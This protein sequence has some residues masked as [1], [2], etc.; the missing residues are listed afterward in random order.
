[1][2]DKYIVSAL[3]VVGTILSVVASS[4]Q[5]ELPGRVQ[6]AEDEQEETKALVLELG[7]E[8]WPSTRSSLGGN[9]EEIFSGAVLAVYDAGTGT[10]DSEI[11]IDGDDIGGKI[12][13][14][15]PSGKSY[16]FYL[17]GNLWEL[18][19]GGGRRGPM[20]PS[21]EEDVKKMIYRMDGG[22][23]EGGFRRERFS[24]VAEFGIPLYW[25]KKGVSAAGGRVEINMRRLFA[26]LAVEI[27]HEGLVG[28]AED[29]FVNG[30]LRIRQVNCRLSP[31]AEEGSR[32]ES[33]DDILDVG[34]FDA[35]MSNALKGEYVYYVPEN[36][37][38][39]LLPEN[40]DPDDKDMD[41]VQAAY[42]G[43]GIEQRLTYVEF[44]GSI[45][46]ESGF[47]GKA[48]YRFFLGKDAVR[49][50]SIERNLRLKVSLGFRS[51]SL[52][53]PDWK[54]EV[55]G[56]SDRREFFLSGELA[57][58][59]PDGQVAVVRKNRPAVLDL[60]LRLDA[61]SNR[62]TSTA[63]VDEGFRPAHLGDM[64]WTSDL[65]SAT[66]DD[67]NEPARK[68]LAD[69]G[70]SVSYESG[71]F[72][73][74]VSDPSR[75]VSGRQVP[76]CFTLYP[77][78]KKLNAAIKTGE[79]ISVTASGSILEDFY[80][81]QHRTLTFSGFEG[82]TIYYAADQGDCT[83][84]S[85]GKHSYNRQWKTDNSLSSPFPTC[86][87]ASDGSA[88]YPY[89]D[90]EAYS[91]QSLPAGE[92]LDIYTFFSNDFAMISGYQN[93]RGSIVI[94]SDDILNDGLTEMRLFIRAPRLHLSDIKDVLLPVDGTE[95]SLGHG[96]YTKAGL[97]AFPE[98]SFDEKLFDALLAPSIELE[99]GTSPWE[100]CIDFDP[101]TGKIW[102]KGT[103]AGGV[104]VGDLTKAE[105]ERIGRVKFS[106]NPATGL[107]SGS[108][109]CA[110]GI[111]LPYL[112][113]EPQAELAST[114]LN[115][116]G[117]TSRIEVPLYFRLDGGD[118]SRYEF[119]CQSTGCTLV[120]EG[121]EFSPVIKGEYK[122]G[123]SG[124]AYYWRY[125]EREQP[126]A[127]P[128]GDFMP[129][130][131]ILPYG[132]QTVT[133]TVVN[134]W[135]GSR[136]SLDTSFNIRHRVTMNQL[137]I[138]GNTAYATIYPL[139]QK[140][141]DY[142]MKY[143]QKAPEEMASWMIKLLGTDV[144]LHNYRSGPDFY[145]S[146]KGKY[147]QPNPYIKYSTGYYHVRYVDDEAYFW[148]DALARKSY[149]NDNYNW[150]DNLKIGGSSGWCADSALTGS[151]W[152]DLFFTTSKGGYIYTGSKVFLPEGN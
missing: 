150:L 32:A 111:S 43:T 5:P 144:W 12:E 79:D 81:A 70:I 67:S 140:N 27:D 112:Q 31:F 142:I 109:S 107:Y 62:I 11:R 50:F 45:G 68:A 33:S 127:V 29:D 131:L 136:V 94:C 39:V 36:M 21:R 75:F 44:E 20:F 49:D 99:S 96:I 121:Q 123:A 102:L 143:H 41:A 65:W 106:A 53:A 56:L 16:D 145:N 152:L 47:S 137:G 77:G 138:F 91:G 82:R 132:R 22:A 120:Y 147:M 15:L 69:L 3:G 135:D 14:Q 122:I 115:E 73:F 108:G 148:S 19:S 103:S 34:D 58:R 52:F 101:L 18:D 9:V 48:V 51:E 118:Q 76:V 71:R 117:F 84:W 128:W 54:L 93:S 146:E 26:R 7:M 55:D 88:L 42:P 66:H 149:Y 134:K 78:A 28:S 25:E 105:A 92:K 4:C 72:T 130:G 90:Y 113:S 86:L 116:S 24:D 17:L 63:L 83:L 40:A 110:F 97:S 124:L 38:G 125:D 74:S 23:T 95:C 57:G 10:L 6:Y 13:L 8:E 30:A 89:Q 37:Q 133:F 46:G 139:P 151:E 104:N 141:I 2:I 126:G 85:S 35:A 98:G 114:Y 59:L 80:I 64:A 119:S 100:E 1:M 87:V 61:G 60:N 129:G